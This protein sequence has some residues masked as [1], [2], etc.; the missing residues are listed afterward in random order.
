MVINVKK[1]YYYVFEVMYEKLFEFVEE[2]M[3]DYFKFFDFLL[4]D[5][6]FI[7]F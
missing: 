4:D 2:D 7:V 1:F 6:I 3:Y 5:N